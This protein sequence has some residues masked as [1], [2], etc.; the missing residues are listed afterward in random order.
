M[1]KKYES[2][3]DLVLHYGQGD[4]IHEMGYIT[5]FTA[6]DTDWGYALR[7]KEG[8]DEIESIE[9]GFESKQKAI[10]H[11]SEDMYESLVEG[12]IDDGSYE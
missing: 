7:G 2:Y 3:E 12:S 10:D 4:D 6:S 1:R 9:V 8:T 11:A 5:V